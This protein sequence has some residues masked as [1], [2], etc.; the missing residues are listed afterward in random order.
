MKILITA[1][2]NETYS[3]Y[4]PDF[5]L[6]RLE[7]SGEVIRNPLDRSLTYEEM[8]EM[9]TDVNVLVTHWGTPKIDAQMLENAPSLQL[10]AHAA[11]SVANLVTEAIYD[12]KIPVLSANPVMARYVA[13][14]V[15]GYMIAGTHRFIQTD[16][17]LRSGG[18]NKLIPQQTSVFD[19]DIGLIGLGTV[20]R[21]LLDLLAP[22]GC[23]VSVYD[24]FI[25]EDA[26]DKWSFAK[27]CDFDTAMSKPIVSVH[28]SKTPE[29]YHMIDEKALAKM[30]DGALLINSALASV[31]DTEALIR[32]LQEKSIYAVIDVYDKEGA[33][34]IAQ[35]LLDE[36]S[37]TLLQPHSAAI[38]GC[39]Q[40]TEAVI[41]DIE[42]FADG[43][44]TQL[45]VSRAQFLLMT[46]E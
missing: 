46:K 16:R 7:K 1:P 13:E 5:L 35:E 40:L 41:D 43:V 18:W 14:S 12:K 9:I 34:N 26:L 6:K 20:G 38:A 23:R 21:I 29:T 33:G 31:I 24:P 2:D 42:R 28:A 11:G 22:F 45:D 8:S 39:W 4:F 10:I 17:I 27:L 19:A 30:A 36:E 32:K 3:R 37:C 25:K 15:L 44:K